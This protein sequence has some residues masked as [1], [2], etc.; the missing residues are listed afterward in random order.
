MRRHHG[1]RTARERALERHKLEVA[2][3][4]GIMVHHHLVD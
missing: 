4:V 2:Q 3:T 1:V